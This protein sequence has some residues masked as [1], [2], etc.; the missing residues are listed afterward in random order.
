MIVCASF[1]R[2]WMAPESPYYSSPKPV[3]VVCVCVVL[4][5]V[6]RNAMYILSVGLLMLVAEK[7]IQQPL[8]VTINVF[9]ICSGAPLRF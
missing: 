8:T 4:P 5:N 3:A 1:V 9:F 2:F 6:L 7:K